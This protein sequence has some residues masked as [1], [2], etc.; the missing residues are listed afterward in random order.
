MN[1]YPQ[2]LRLLK[3]RSVHFGYSNFV[4]DDED[5]VSY[6]RTDAIPLPDIIAPIC[7]ALLSFS[8]VLE[9]LLDKEYLWAGVMVLGIVGWAWQSYDVLKERKKLRDQIYADPS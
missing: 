7:C 8:F 4:E 1:E 3:N 9:Y 6:T 2:F 5:G